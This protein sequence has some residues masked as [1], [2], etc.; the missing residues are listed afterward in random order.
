MDEIISQLATTYGPPGVVIAVLL[1]A[2]RV[3]YLGNEK[4]AE[5]LNSISVKYAE[6]AVTVVNSIDKLTDSVRG[7]VD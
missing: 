3:L 2:I 4:K 6:L 5:A 7:K 1:Y